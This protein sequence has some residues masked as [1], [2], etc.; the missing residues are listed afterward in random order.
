MRED[1]NKAAKMEF[2]EQPSP[3]EFETA[4]KELRS[5]YIRLKYEVITVPP[6]IAED[7]R[8]DKRAGLIKK[9]AKLS[10]VGVS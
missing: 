6:W 8:I 9:T 1:K 7:Q 4:L 3:R 2:F 5:K 10:S